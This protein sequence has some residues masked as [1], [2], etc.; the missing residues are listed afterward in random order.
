MKLK[1][2]LCEFAGSR[3]VVKEE[4]LG[5]KIFLKLKRENKVGGKAT[6]NAID[7]DEQLKLEIPSIVNGTD[8]LQVIVFPITV[9][10][11]TKY[12]TETQETKEESSKGL[13]TKDFMHAEQD[14]LNDELKNLSNSMAVKSETKSTMKHKGRVI[15]WPWHIRCGICHN[16]QLLEAGRSTEG[17][18]KKFKAAHYEHCKKQH[19]KKE[20]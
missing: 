17:R 19:D 7:T 4:G 10:F 18:L 2:D 11:A 16:E 1:N 8:V 14:K 6:C 5:D 9:S 13:Q 15:E 3:A 12:P 20:K